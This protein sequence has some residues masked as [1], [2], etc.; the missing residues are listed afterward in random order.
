MA[1]RVAV[2]DDYHDIA[3]SHYGKLDP[4]RYA[5]EY[6]PT[7]ALPYSHTN[8][9]QAEKDK[10]VARLQAFEVIGKDTC[11][12]HPFLNLILAY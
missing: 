1:I 7:T 4:S 10:L 11:L 8:T 3:P 5:I 9:P 6:F 2:L 12:V